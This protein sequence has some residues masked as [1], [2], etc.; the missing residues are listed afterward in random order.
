MRTVRRRHQ[1]LAA[2]LD[3]SYEF[4][5]EVERVVLRRLAVFAGAFTLE[6]AIAVAGDDEIDVVEAV[7]NLVTKS[8]VS[9]DVSAPIVQYRLLD[10]TRAYASQK[11]IQASEF[12]DCVRRHAQHHV[13]W[14]KHAESDWERRSIAEWFDEYG[15]RLDDVRSALNWAFSP[16]GDSSIGVA[17]TVASIPLWRALSLVHE[18]HACIERAL[19]SQA[20]QPVH[21][22]HD[23][24][25]LLE[26]LGPVQ[27]HALSRVP[28]DDGL[29]VRALALAERL[30]D[31]P[32]QG[33]VLFHWS[34]NH[35]YAENFRE[36]L[37]LAEKCSAIANKGD[38]ALVQMMGNVVLGSAQLS[39]GNHLSVLS[40]LKPIVNQVLLP[41]QLRLSMLRLQAEVPLCSTLWLTGLPDQAVDCARLAA[42]GARS[43]DNA[44]ILS[45][46]LA[47]TTCL[48]ALYVGDLAEAERS[49]AMLLGCTA[50]YALHTW[51]AVARCL[52]GRLLLAQ[53]DFAGLAV[54]RTALDWIREARFAVHYTISLG[55]LAEGLTAAGQLVEAHQAINEALERTERNEELWCLPELL[56]I[57]GELIRAD[58]PASGNQT[59][60]DC[61]Q[62]A[63]DLA[64]SQQALSWELRAAMSLAKLWCRDGKT[65][66]A[67]N[68]LTAVYGRFTE[69]F[70]TAD[71]KCARALIDAFDGTPK[72]H[73]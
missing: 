28:E 64:R 8:L 55:A 47:R 61:F 11:L 40:H 21:N 9:A 41:N 49:V 29:W 2:A 15:R 67:S 46:I 14:F 12:D 35:R 13:D 70:E 3:W 71:L 52:Q 6:S 43:S 50:K 59:A 34:V 72:R 5:P 32:A 31:E 17:L 63:L 66:E 39:M 68:L 44:L 65:A 1:T 30:G 45:N 53:G 7:L 26:A 27:P 48:M 23:E 54:L 42:D 58:G 37:A 20:A 62:Q 24:L 36:A 10:T 33:R 19:A 69:G 25:R 38:D 16:D 51:N 22:E 57:K 18:A 4:L 60:E 56:R 73:A